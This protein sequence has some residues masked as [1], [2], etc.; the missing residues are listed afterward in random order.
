VLA[1]ETGHRAASIRLLRWDDVDLRRRVA[2]WRSENDKIGFQHETP[3][4]SEAV[5]VLEEARAKRPAIGNAWV[6]PAP[7]DSREPVHRQTLLKWWGKARKLAKIPP[8]PGLGYHGL[9][10]KFATEL[11]GAPLRDL[12]D[13]GGW[14]A[15]QTVVQVYQRPDQN[16]MREALSSRRPLQAVGQ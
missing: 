7:R 2:T 13:L 15:P 10:R 14:K 9:R 6:F 5:R 1:H 16:T 4:S 3:L 11:K 12:M 8:T